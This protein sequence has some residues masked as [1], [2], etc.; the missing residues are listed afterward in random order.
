MFWQALLL[1]CVLFTTSPSFL[2]AEEVEL[3]ASSYLGGKN[4]DDSVVGAVIQQ[5]GTIVLAANLGE[6]ARKKLNVKGNQ[7]GCLLF[8][9]SNGQKL[10]SAQSLAEEV[11]DLAQDGNDALFLAAGTEGIL[12][13]SSDGKQMLWKKVIETEAKG[14]KGTARVTRIDAGKEDY[15]ACIEG[16]KVHIF[17]TEGKPL[18]TAAGGQFTCDVCVDSASQTV[19]QTG[20]RNANAFDGKRKFPVQICYLRGHH[21]DGQLKWSNYDWSTKTDSNRFLNK[22]TN[23]MADSRGDRCAIG[24]D[25]KLYVTFQVAGG[26]H[27]FRYHPRDIMKKVSLVGG[28]NYH[29]FHNSRAEHKCFFA[30]FEP[31]TGNFLLGQQFCTR[32]DKGRAGYAATKRG[33]ITADAQGRVYIV[34][35]ADPGL[36]LTMNPSKS[37]HTGGGFILVMSSDFQKRLLCT[38]LCGGAG[39]PHA[40][41]VQTKNGVAHTLFGGS[42]MKEGLFLKEPI[43]TQAEDKGTEKNDPKEGFF[44]LFEL[45]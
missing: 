1:V 37:E 6:S 11:H 38:R 20:F 16:R 35:Y 5:D 2:M 40:L 41:A 21:L 15:V 39:N 14:K 42:K 34:G 26:N 32:R 25:G 18:G 30:R 3:L 23:N 43:Q 7:A 29:K 10:I 33:N 8:L 36:P 13:C 4:F 9:S 12:K 22:P 24:E 27:L 45:K 44:A 31:A 17:D 28:D 19:I